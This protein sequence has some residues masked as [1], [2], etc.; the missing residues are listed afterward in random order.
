MLRKEREEKGIPLWKFAASVPFPA[1]NLQRIETGI[2]EPRIGTAMKM[3]VTLDMDAGNFMQT[4]AEA[5]GWEKYP[6][7]DG[8]AP[9]ILDSIA[10]KVRSEQDAVAIAAKTIFGAYFRL[11][12]LA[13]GLK[14]AQIA[15]RASYTTRSLIA[16][17]NGKQEPMVMRA[18]ELVWVMGVG[19]RQFFESFAEIMIPRD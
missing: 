12:R 14:Q 17:E 10:E 5:Q 16:V 1:S 2:T 11:V 4:L 13:C 19:V 9:E 3:L 6:V 8:F 7:P 15:A 18:L